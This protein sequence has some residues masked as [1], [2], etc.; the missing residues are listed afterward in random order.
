VQCPNVVRVLYA[1]LDRTGEPKV[2]AID[3][4]GFADMPLIEEK[5]GQG[6]PRGMHPC[7]RLRVGQV[8]IKLN[9]AAELPIRLF[10]TALMIGELS[11][12]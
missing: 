2:V 12:Q 8:V 10:V 6:M 3:L 1:P 11:V 9:G 7:P 5:S 4:L